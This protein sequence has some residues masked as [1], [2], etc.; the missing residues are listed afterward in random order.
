MNNITSQWAEL[1]DFLGLEHTAEGIEE[2]MAMEELWCRI[3][4]EFL[5]PGSGVS[6]LPEFIGMLTNLREI[7]IENNLITELPDSMCKLVNLQELYVSG[8]L[9]TSLPEGLKNLE[10]L[11]ILDVSYNCLTVKP[12][13]FRPEIS[14]TS[15]G[16][17]F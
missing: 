5:L 14:L 13:G 16:N 10:K 8:N 3:D 4:L 15:Y 6:M 7:R 11:E 12:E 9:L 1:L 17:K 2:A